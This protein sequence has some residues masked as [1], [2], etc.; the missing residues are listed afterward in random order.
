MGAVRRQLGFRITD[1]R[2]AFLEDLA[3]QERTTIQG[4][5]DRA[6]DQF[7][8]HRLTGPTGDVLRDAGLTELEREF[9]S[10]MLWLFRNSDRETVRDMRSMARVMRKAAEASGRVREERKAG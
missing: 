5:L 2:R 9:I 1:D 6:V 7:L 10:E 3:H 8:E 4:V